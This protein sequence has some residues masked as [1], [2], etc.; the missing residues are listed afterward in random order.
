MRE[1]LP[2]GN[3]TRELPNTNPNEETRIPLDDDGQPIVKDAGGKAPGDTGIWHV[4]RIEM[5]R[6]QD[7][8]AKV[9]LTGVVGKDE[10]PAEFPFL[11]NN[12]PVSMIKQ[13]FDLIMPETDWDT[14]LNAPHDDDVNWKV[15]YRYSNKLNTKGYYFKNITGIEPWSE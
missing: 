4:K 15:S 6:I 10:K 14:Y 9:V 8:K 11:Q 7:G 5:S 2:Y 12:M 1:T 3:K 13:Y